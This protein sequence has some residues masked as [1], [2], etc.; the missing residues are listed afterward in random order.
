VLGCTPHSWLVVLLLKCGTE[1]SL[2]LD[3][4]FHNNIYRATTVG[5]QAPTYRWLDQV[6]VFNFHTC[7]N[8]PF[9]LLCSCVYFPECWKYF[10]FVSQQLPAKCAELSLLCWLLQNCAGLCSWAPAHFRLWGEQRVFVDF[11][12][13]ASSGPRDLW[14]PLGCRLPSLLSLTG[15]LLMSAATATCLCVCGV[16]LS[17]ALLLITVGFSSDPASTQRCGNCSRMGFCAF[18]G[19]FVRTRAQDGGRKRASP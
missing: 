16:W 11:P 9:L 3:C 7:D 18:L 14:T 10:H 13:T 12:R 15:S 8:N 6:Y 4:Q 2:F 5:V 1:E 17:A 19:L